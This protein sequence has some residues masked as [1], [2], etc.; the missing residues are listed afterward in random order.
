LKKAELLLAVSGIIGRVDIEQ[1]LA[2]FADL[3]TA[4]MN[5]LLKQR[6]IHPHQIAGRRCVLPAAESGLG[7]ECVSQFLIGE[8]L[9]KRIVAQ[10]VRVIGVLV[11][12]HD[13]VDALPQEC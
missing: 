6:V 10:T 2:A 12:G 11:A 8:D 4:K 3:L 9:Q 13:L 5:E 1:D 7:T